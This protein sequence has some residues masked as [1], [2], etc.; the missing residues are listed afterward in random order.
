MALPDPHMTIPGGGMIEIWNGG[1]LSQKWAWNL[2]KGAQVEIVHYIY[3]CLEAKV[4]RIFHNIRV[5][6]FT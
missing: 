5:L 3:R 6:A 1:D 4:Q 2:G